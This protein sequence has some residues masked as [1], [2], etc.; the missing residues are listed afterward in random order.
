MK[1]FSTLIVFLAIATASRAQAPDVIVTD[2]VVNAPIDEVWKAF[3]TKEGIEAWMVAKTDIDLR[4]GG[5]WRTSYSATSTLD[6]D[7]AIQQEIL[8]FDAPRMFSFRTVNPPRTFPFPAAIV[9]TWTIVYFEPTAEARTRVTI[10]MLGFSDDAESVR[11]RAFFE[12]GNRQTL[13]ELIGWFA[14]TGRTP[15]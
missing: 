6:D 12:Q 2:G 11:M 7:T 1:L 5:S 14:A 15:R 4:P 13:D 9:K 8:A 10:R 3:T